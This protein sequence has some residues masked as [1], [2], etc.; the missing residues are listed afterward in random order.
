MRKIVLAM[1]I[2]ET[3]LTIQDI[4]VVVDCGRARR[5]RYDPSKGLQKLVTE[6]VSKAEATQRAGR[7]GRI[8]PGRCYRMWASAE[9]GAMPGFAPPEIEISDLA[10]LALELA[11]W[12]H[13]PRI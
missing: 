11:Q 9:E 13:D 1:A 10:P 12:A 6:R 5:A 7:A 2:A 3:S 4:L 8:A